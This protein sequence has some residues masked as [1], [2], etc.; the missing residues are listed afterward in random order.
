MAS[1]RSVALAVLVSLSI[2]TA[3]SIAHAQP[4]RHG[5]ID[6]HATAAARATF[7]DGLA[8][9]DAGDWPCAVERF[10]R[11]RAMHASPVIVFN[12]GIAL[13]HVGRVVEASETFRALARDASTPADLRVA[14]AHGETELARRIGRITIDVVGPA[15]GVAVSMDASAVDAALLGAAIPSDPGDHVIEARRD[16]Q[17]VAR[18]R[19]HVVAASGARVELRI[20][21]AET[22]RITTLAPEI[23]VLDAQGSRVAPV[24]P[25]RHEVYEEW[26]LW[27]L[28]GLAVVGAGVGIG[29]GVAATSSAS[30]P[31]GS[32]G[33]IDG[34]L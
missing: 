13:A 16:G 32:L 3:T 23:A 12:H 21:P 19:V 34:R 5:S 2:S 27:T 20:P 17:L 11:A 15:E 6:A 8:C 14:A 18:A 9:A 24:P 25:P 31:S 30:P 10:G 4:A 26:W 1:P 28:V 29:F 22:A 7:V 33:T